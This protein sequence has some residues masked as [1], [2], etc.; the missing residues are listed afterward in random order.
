MKRLFTTLLFS[1]ALLSVWAVPADPFPVEVRQPDGTLLTILQYGDEDFHYVTTTDGVLLY[2]DGHAYYIAQTASDGSLECT[3]QLA[4][5]AS[6]RGASERHLIEMQDKALFLATAEVRQHA[7]KILREPVTT[8]QYEF[9]HMGSPKAIVILAEFSD[10][11]FTISNPKR[12]FD[13]YLN[14]EGEPEEYGF[15][16]NNNYESVGEYMRT[17]SFGQFTP[18]F[19]VYGP[20]RL[21]SPLKTYGGTSSTGDGEN[22]NKLLRDACTL[23]DD[24]LDFSQYDENN[25]GYV[26]LLIVIY[27]GYS[28]AVN[29]N[30]NECIWPKSGYTSSGTY[31][32]KTIYRYAVSSEL[33]GFPN[34]YSRAPFKRINGIGVFCHEFSHCIG[35]PDMYPTTPSVKGDNQAMEFWSLMDSGCYLINGTAP[36][37]YTAWERETMGWFSIDT[38][39][40]DTDIEMLP[41]DEGGKAYR[42]LNDNDET[43]HEYFVIENIQ[44]RGINVRQKGHGLLVSHVNYDQTAFSLSSNN[45]NNIKGK[46]RMTVVP[47]DGLLFA[48]YNIDGVNIKNQDFYDQLAGDPFPGTSH[49]TELNDTMGIVNFQVYNG[50]SLN[51]ALSDISETANGTIRFHFVSDFDA[52]GISEATLPEGMSDGKI[53]TLDGRYVGRTEALLPKGIYIKSGKKIIK[54]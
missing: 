7:H 14:G 31:D 16:E 54:R 46:P 3:T 19:D 53:Y 4:H 44:D 24:S 27:A 10:T 36:A 43:G 26:D 9:P 15:G 34:C 13:Q 47:A 8:S 41:L 18:Q 37:A 50:E 42:I 48:Q 39:R 49:I 17:C 22:M 33:N 28:Q 40:V 12:S 2:Q 1:I 51:K 30:S 5:E 52:L 25:D 45:V 11:T 32:G 23:M 6:R 35:L 21:S 20:V 29:G 38:L